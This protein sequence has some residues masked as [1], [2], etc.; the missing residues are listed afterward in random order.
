MENYNQPSPERIELL[1]R[2]EEVVG[3]VTPYLWAACQICDL[4]ALEQ[5]LGHPSFFYEGLNYTTRQMVRY[6]SSSLGVQSQPSTPKTSTPKTPTPQKSTASNLDLTPSM[7]P[8][9]SKRQKTLDSPTPLPRDLNIKKRAEERDNFSCVLTGIDTIQVAH[10]YPHYAMKYSEDRNG[11]RHKFWDQLKAFWSEEKVTAWE[12]K[13]F[14]QGIY[15]K[16]SEEV[17]NLISLAPTVHEIW[18]QGLFALK[19]ISMS[20]DQKTLKV[21][22]F[23]QERQKGPLPRMSLTTTPISTEGLQQTTGAHGGHTWLFDK[24]GKKIQSGDCFTLQTDNPIQKPLP[25]FE[26]LELQWFLHRIRGM[27]GAAEVEW[28][29]WLDTDSNSDN[30]IEEV[31]GLGFD[32][33]VEDFSLLSDE[34]LP[35][36]AKSSNLPLHPKHVTT[37]V[38]GDGDREGG[39]DLVM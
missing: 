25:N 3:T 27:A 15:E 7:L 35:S 32:N 37:E 39:R 6:W 16:G 9:P 30:A 36:P 22:F 21:Q 10:I 18:G 11:L 1:K 26:L 19:P 4:S 5:L 14:P 12:A 28:D 23:W 20:E 34:P 38:E 29:H 8:P 17:Y 13:L 24:N 33:D 31:P 2:L